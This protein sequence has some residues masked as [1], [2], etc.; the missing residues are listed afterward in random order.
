[1]NVQKVE[2]E[3]KAAPATKG[4][5]K[6]DVAKPFAKVLAEKTP[7]PQLGLPMIQDTMP[8]LQQTKQISAPALP[9]AMQNLVQ[10]IVVATGPENK[11]RVDIQ[12][13][14]KTFDGLK[15]SITHE[16]GSVA[17]QM[18]S[19]TPEVAAVLNRNV[20]QLQVAL[21]ERGV[22]VS[23]IRVQTVRTPGSLPRGAGGAGG[24]QR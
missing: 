7:E 23:S 4:K 15:I 1:M 2:A 5:D 3:A 8:V 12:L 14:S 18:T 22:P 10:E 24:R 21:V 20:D 6:K 19:A 9:P 13:N 17:I 16:K 11:A